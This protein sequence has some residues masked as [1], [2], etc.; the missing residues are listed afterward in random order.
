MSQ[1]TLVLPAPYGAAAALGIMT[2]LPA[3]QP[4]PEGNVAT[5]I[6]ECGRPG[7]LDRLARVNAVC[8]RR[9]GYGLFDR[10]AP[11]GWAALLVSEG[12]LARAV[13]MGCTRQGLYT[14]RLTL[15]NIHP[16]PFGP[17]GSVPRIEA[18]RT[19]PGRTNPAC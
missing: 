19:P 18:A 14:W 3:E 8:R 15:T 7:Y 17:A 1:T 13:I 11:A 12:P 10:C 9:R 16:L 5:V 4:Y 6:Q 2:H